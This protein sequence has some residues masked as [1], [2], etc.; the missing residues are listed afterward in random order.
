MPWEMTLQ[1]R[2]METG[3]NENENESALRNEAEMG[4]IESRLPYGVTYLDDLC[5]RTILE[6]GRPNVTAIS[7]SQPGSVASTIARSANKYHS[8][9]IECRNCSENFSSRDFPSHELQEEGKQC[10]SDAYDHDPDSQRAHD[11]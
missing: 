8:N 2:H 9:S 7:A 11:R 1:L 6:G 3:R 4:K 10:A 5:A